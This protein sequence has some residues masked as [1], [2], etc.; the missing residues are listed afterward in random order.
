MVGLAAKK[1]AFLIGGGVGRMAGET[2]IF[3]RP[4]G[5]LLIKVAQAN[6]LAFL[7]IIWYG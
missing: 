6:S 2:F 5:F 3:T 1:I 4:L 7:R